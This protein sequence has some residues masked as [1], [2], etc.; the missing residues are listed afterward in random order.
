MGRPTAIALCVA[1]AATAFACDGGGDRS[2]RAVAGTV[3][4]GEASAAP[5]S[6]EGVATGSPA[7]AGMTAASCFADL[8]GPVAAPNYDQFAPT[9]AK[10][11]S[12]TAHQK[13]ER[14]EKVVFLGDS[15]TAGTPP[16]PTGE[17]YREQLTRALVN[18]FG[19]IETVS[20]AA[21]GATVGDL[22]KPGGQ[23]ATCFPSG[24]EA[25]R[26]LVVM[27]IGGNDVKGWTEDPSNAV[28]HAAAAGAE[29]RR[30]VE[31]LTSKEHFPKGSYVTFAN[32]YEFTDASGDLSSC[33]AGNLIGLGGSLLTIAPAVVRLEEEMMKTAVE[34]KTDMIFLLEHF[35]GH[36]YRREDPSLQ[37]YRGPGVELWFDFTCIHPTPTG[38]AEI[39]R[40]FTAAVD[41]R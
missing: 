25:K 16:T 28:A 27:T 9:I 26:T 2:A 29:F 12:S 41:G 32:V 8:A 20:C 17:Y 18:R 37:C 34:T 36:G 15:V 30:A 7:P 19:S 31:W 5:P 21:W 4:S 23:I 35:C 14:V 6:S 13:I 11:C 3:P 24:V 38:H 40:L 33:P 22:R 1:V 10:S 39:A